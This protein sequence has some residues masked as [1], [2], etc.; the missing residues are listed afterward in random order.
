MQSTIKRHLAVVAATCQRHTASSLSR[1][2]LCTNL[3][4]TGPKATLGKRKA[5]RKDKRADEE[6]K[7]LLKNEK[8]AAYSL[9]VEDKRAARS[10]RKLTKPHQ[11]LELLESDDGLSVV[12]IA[13]GLSKIIQQHS[14]V[15]RGKSLRVSADHV[16][17]QAVRLEEAFLAEPERAQPRTLSSVAWITTTLGTASSELLDRVSIQRRPFVTSA[18]VRTDCRRRSGT[19]RLVQQQRHHATTLRI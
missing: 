17:E 2:A 1:R 16:R 14:A 13:T 18:H 6:F 12:N 15:R 11:V 10:L 3:D 4:R 7:S 5:S 8:Q 19:T 9:P